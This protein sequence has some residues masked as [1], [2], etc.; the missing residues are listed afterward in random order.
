MFQVFYLDVAYVTVALYA[1]FTCFRLMLQ[2]F[3]LDIAKVDLNVA[4]VVMTIHA[5]FKHMFQVFQMYV[6]N[7][8]S[9]C[10]KSRSKRAHAS[11]VVVAL[12]LLLGVPCGSLCE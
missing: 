7:I 4:Y 9:G 3:H 10:F 8:S 6:V 11:S 2:V 5:C 12:L 1:C